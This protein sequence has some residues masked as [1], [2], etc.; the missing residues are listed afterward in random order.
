MNKYNFRWVDIDGLYRC[1][2]VYS[3]SLKN[4]VI[5]LA[6]LTDELIRIVDVD[7]L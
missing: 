4:A 3:D 6:N 5:E 1:T 7:F 2:V